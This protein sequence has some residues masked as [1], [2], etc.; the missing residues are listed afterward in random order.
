MKMDK[1]GGSCNT[2]CE[3]TDVY[4]IEVGNLRGRDSLKS[5][6]K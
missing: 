4:K 3:I 2:H 5:R 1:M 6:G